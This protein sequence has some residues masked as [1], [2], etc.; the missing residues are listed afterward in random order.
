LFQFDLD[1][2][3][4]TYNAVVKKTP[5]PPLS[6]FW[7]V[8][9]MAAALQRLCLRPSAVTVSLYYLP[10]CLRQCCHSLFCKNH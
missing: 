3:K 2:D 8:R 1:K 10:R 9:G 7:E 4:I 6:L 5:F